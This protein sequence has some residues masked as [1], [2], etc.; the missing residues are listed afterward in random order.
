MYLLLC[1]IQYTVIG[2]D[3]GYYYIKSSINPN[4]CLFVNS[5]ISYNSSNYKGY[6]LTCS[7]C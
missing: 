2:L 4:V 1:L 7:D 6:Y 3:S 5:S